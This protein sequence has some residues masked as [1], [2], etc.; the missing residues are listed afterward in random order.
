[1]LISSTHITGQ[2]GAMTKQVTVSILDMLHEK[3]EKWGT[4]L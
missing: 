2:E 4:T 1:M 3:L